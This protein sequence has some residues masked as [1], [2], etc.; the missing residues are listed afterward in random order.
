METVRKKIAIYPGTF[1]PFTI[2]HLNIS[3]KTEAIFGAENV[4]IAVGV[5]PEKDKNNP[6]G[7]SLRAQTIKGNLPSRNVEHYKGFLTDYVFEKEKLGF[8]VTIVRGL[9]Q[10]FDL[11]YEMNLLRVMQDFKPDIKVMY[12]VCDKEFDHVSSSVYR[13]CEIEKPGSGHRYLAKEIPQP[14]AKM[15]EESKCQV[16]VDKE[17]V[18]MMKKYI[19]ISD[20]QSIS[21]NFDFHGTYLECLVWI[22]EQEIK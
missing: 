9:R 10:G 14:S 2:G 1:D 19:I 13:F 5:N 8:D 18:D 17:E 6:N 11:H 20:N 3:E 21:T 7:A 22:K 12:F 4:I 15:V 16:F